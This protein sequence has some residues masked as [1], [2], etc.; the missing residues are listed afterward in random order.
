VKKGH[1]IAMDGLQQQ[2]QKSL[3]ANTLLEEQLKDQERQNLKKDK[4]IEDLRKAT[5]DFDKL[6]EGFNE[7]LHHFQDTL[8][9]TT[10]SYNVK[11]F[12][13]RY[14]V[15]LGQGEADTAEGLRMATDAARKELDGLLNAGR[16]ACG[17]LQIAGSS[18]LSAIALTQ[19]LLL[20]PGLMADW[21]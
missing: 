21:K 13:F 12:N 6:R 19:K 17:S 14:A 18:N 9:G 5:A 15:A 4:E 16:Q 8:L 20:V 3:A 10:S 7:L 2:L 1:A 11:F